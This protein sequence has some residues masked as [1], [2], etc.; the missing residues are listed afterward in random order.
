MFLGIPQCMKPATMWPSQRKTNTRHN[1]TPPHKGAAILRH[2]M[3]NG[4]KTKEI[5]KHDRRV[6]PQ[7]TEKADFNTVVAVTAHK[8][9]NHPREFGVLNTISLHM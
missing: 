1:I 8:L 5:L 2:R 3:E 6:A 9:R 7:P 4:K